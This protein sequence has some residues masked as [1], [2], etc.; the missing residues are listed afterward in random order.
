MSRFKPIRA[1]SPPKASKRSAATVSD[2]LDNTLASL[3]SLSPELASLTSDEID[4]IETVIQRAVPSTSSFQIVLRVYNE[5]LRERGLD[6]DQETVLYNKLLKVGTIKG[7]NW[8]EK[9]D[10]VKRQQHPQA[11]PSRLKPSAPV[12]IPPSAPVA[13]RAQI[14]TRL[15]GALKAMEQDEDAFTLHSHQDDTDATQ[16]EPATELGDEHGPAF[17]NA[18][19]RVTTRTIRRPPT[20]TTATSSVG[21]S[22][23]PSYS[24]GAAAPAYD[25]TRRLYQPRAPVWDA[26]TSDATADTAQASSSIPPSYGAATR[27][28]NITTGTS[29]YTPLRALA[30]AQSKAIDPSPTP[31]NTH[32]VLPSA[33]AAVLEARKRRGSVI[34]EDDA[35]KKIQMARDEEEADRFRE[36]RLIERCWDVWKQGY[37]WIVVCLPP[38]HQPA[39]ECPTQFF[40]FNFRPRMNKLQRRETILS[41]ASHCTDGEVSRRPDVQSTNGSPQCQ[42][43]DT[44]ER[45][46]SFGVSNFVSDNR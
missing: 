30:K 13:R 36:E 22:V 21:I 12:R 33:R 18:T 45:P 43:T 38:T 2:I 20:H 10:I 19:P 8:G 34:N 3:P 31:V 11:G 14:L 32:P 40:S 46:C 6:P 41:S 44:S 7:K 4:F 1:S 24:N 15:T 25:V 27:T 16:S 23:T 42:T 9:W 39:S 26:D 37:Q 35:W 29:S 5:L 28:A 17:S